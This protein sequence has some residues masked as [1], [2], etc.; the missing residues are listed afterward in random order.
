VRVRQPP[1]AVRKR[2]EASLLTAPANMS[3]NSTAGSTKAY[4]G[5]VAF[6]AGKGHPDFPLLSARYSPGSCIPCRDF[7][8]WIRDRL[9]VGDRD[10]LVEYVWRIRAANPGVGFGDD[11]NA[12][13]R[14]FAPQVHRVIDAPLETHV[15]STDPLA[16]EDLRVALVMVAPL[17]GF[18]GF[19]MA[20]KV[21]TYI[22]ATMLPRVVRF[23]GMGELH[24]RATAF[25]AAMVK[26]TPFWEGWVLPDPNAV[27]ELIPPNN[28][29]DQKLRSTLA[30]LQ[31][32]SRAHAVDVG[33][34]AFAGERSGRVAFALEGRTTFV[35]R[36][37][38][39]DPEESAVALL[40]S[41][42]F[43]TPEDPSSYLLGLTQRELV[44]L[45]VGHAVPIKRSWKKDKIA[46]AIGTTA[47]EAGATA[48]SGHHVGLLT[49]ELAPAFG[50]A[51]SWI[52]TTAPAWSLIVSFA[53]PPA[54]A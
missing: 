13:A 43:T 5:L 25:V 32:G 8:P 6:A 19:T 54:G 33:R 21:P 51:L 22:A 40:E 36:E 46:A 39:C 3:R 50:R 27:E 30:L 34:A 47:P 15:M 26:D 7:S 12:I 44:G 17:D 49:P 42:L 4:E 31:I 1:V 48:M 10:A 45:A 2:I 52:Q 11:P 20:Q 24:A 41:G 16:L 23:R 9:R 18:S 38:G 28:P 29:L 53:I 14:I 37:R 35:T